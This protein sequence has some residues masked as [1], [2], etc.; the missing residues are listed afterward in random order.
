MTHFSELFAANTISILRTMSFSQ[1]VE[2]NKPLLP[3][4]YF[5]WDTEEGNVDLSLESR[6]GELFEIWPKVTGKPRWFSLN[7]SLGDCTFEAG[8]VIGVIVE[9]EGAKGETFRFFTRSARGEKMTDTQF[10][11]ALKG[12]EDISVQTVLHTLTGSD[13]LVQGQGFHTLILPLPLHD[14]T[15]RLRDLRVI[16]IPASRGLRSGPVTLAGRGG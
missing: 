8:D 10:E 7:L 6:T 11:D 4:V 9:F 2:N 16:V 13:A 5:S 3:G 14:V 1:T 12:S 15:L